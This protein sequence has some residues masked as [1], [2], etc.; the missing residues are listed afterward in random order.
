MYQ[1]NLIPE[2]EGTLIFNSL[3]C[4]DGTII[5]SYNTHDYIT[6]VDKVTGKTYMVDGGLSYERRSANGDEMNLSQILTDDHEHNRNFAF[7]GSYGKKG[8]GP[9]KWVSPRMMTSDH[10]DAVL[11]KC[12]YI[13]RWRYRLYLTELEYRRP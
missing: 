5:T 11:E 10:I 3:M 1:S 12:L 9:L 13:P 8:K 7:W 6:H 2:D 4:P